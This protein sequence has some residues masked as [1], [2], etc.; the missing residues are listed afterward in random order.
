MEVNA[1]KG[2]NVVKWISSQSFSILA[3]S[4]NGMPHINYVFI[5][6]YSNKTLKSPDNQYQ[7]PKRKV[8]AA[9]D[10]SQA[11]TEQ[12]SAISD[13]ISLRSMLSPDLE[14]ELSVLFK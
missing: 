8:A 12:T 10:F 4:P 11:P 2:C 3:L 13:R 6:T 5:L 14:E 7:V 9:A 1:G